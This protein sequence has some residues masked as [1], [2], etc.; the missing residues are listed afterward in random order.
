MS[1][2][3]IPTEF[4]V[5]VYGK[6]EQL[7][8]TLSKCR[9]R[10]FYKGMNRNRT[11]ITEEFAQQLIDSLPYT[12]VKGIFDSEE[13]DYTDHGKKN[14]EGK[15]YGIVPERHNFAWEF[16]VDTDGVEREY[17]CADVLLFT[18]IYPE[19]KLIPEKGQSM[20]IY[21]KT[22]VGEWKLDEYGEPYY[23]FEKGCFIGLQIL[24]DMTEPCFEGAAFY[25]LC[26]DVEKLVTYIKQVQEKEEERKKMDK[27]L[28]RLSDHDKAR[29]LEA[30]LNPNFNEEGNWVQDRAVM[31]VYD[32]YAICFN[33]PEQQYERAYYT[34]DEDKV[35]LGEIVE[36][37]I[38]DVT[39]DERMALEAIKAVSGTYEVAKASL[40]EAETLKTTL[41]EKETELS[42]KETEFAAKQTELE[43]K[44]SGL[45]ASAAEFEVQKMESENK[46]SEFST[47]IEALEAEKVEMGQ[48]ISDITSENES[49]TE[50]KHQIEL[51]QKEGILSKYTEYLDEETYGQ[52]KADIDKY[53]VTDFKKEVCTAA[54]ES[55]QTIFSKNTGDTLYYSLGS[56]ESEDKAPVSG[57]ERILNKHKK[58][59]G[60]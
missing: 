51:E 21:E 6:P 29:A 56:V 32:D 37:F 42:T 13:I 23:L 27:T 7:T 31:E 55:S 30:L 24:G 26:N 38:V 53:S 20:E 1:Q 2:M 33:I 48:K 54:V 40:E 35:V 15:I 57:V 9:V 44:I 22:L 11:F 28:F 50:F 47:Q 4:N 41:S 36:V 12:P 14:S 8:P 16:H 5:E 19:A 60:K 34:K 43:E 17:G 25:S 46:I 39:E 49:L 58:N 59:G 52:L 3:K 18:A 10:I 45:E